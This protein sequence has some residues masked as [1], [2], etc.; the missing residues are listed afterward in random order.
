[1]RGSGA[2]TRQ[3]WF[4][5]V[6]AASSG[7]EGARASLACVRTA[8]RSV[9]S[10]VY[11]GEG[12]V[13]T[14]AHVVNECLGRE[15]FATSRPTS[16]A[17]HVF[18]P[19]APY[20]DTLTARLAVWIPARAEHDGPGASRPSQGASAV[21]QG[22]LAVLELDCEPP[23]PVRPA[24]WA[25]M[26]QEQRVRAWYSTGQPFTYADGQVEW[27]DAQL[28][29]VDA[30][31]RGAAIGPGYSGGP[32][33]CDG[34]Q[35]AVGVVLGVL[36][37]PEGPFRPGDVTRRTLALPWQAVRAEL[38]AVE[39]HPPGSTAPWSG[40][41]YEVALVDPGT[42]H[43]IAAVVAHLCADPERRA[44]HADRLT[45]ELGLTRAPGA[46]PTVD[47]IVDLLLT[48][49]RALAVLTEG[50]PGSEREAALKLLFLG[51]AAGVLG[52]LS[53]R[54]YRWLLDLLPPEAAARL[55][56][57]ARA[58]LP[59]TTLFDGAPGEV[60]QPPEA[61]CAPPPTDTTARLV[62]ALEG[63]WG[64][65][66][67]VPAGSPRVP[68]LL[69][70]MEY[71]AATYEEKRSRDLRDWSEQVAH[72]LGV[73]AE[74]LGER[75]DDAVA[76]ARRRQQDGT[77]AVPRLTVRLTRV[78]GETFRCE[79]W[80][81]S[82]MS[83]AAP[84]DAAGGVERLVV[85]DDMDR[86][87]AQIARLLHGVLARERT[88]TASPDA[89]G[90]LIEVLLEADDLDVAVDQ[91]EQETSP[92]EVPVVLG[93]EYAVVIRCP[94][95]RRRV[96]ERLPDWRARWAE[97]ERGGG[98][99]RLDRRHTTRHQVYG[100]LT[101]DPGLARVI[102]DCAEE[103][104]GALRA[105]CL[106]LGVPVVV[107]DRCA[108]PAPTGG[109]RLLA[110]VLNGPPKGLP[111]RVRRHRARALAEADDSGHTAVTPALVWDDASRLPPRALWSDPS[112]EDPA[113]LGR[114]P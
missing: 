45:G 54:E 9:G 12:R 72:R 49:P 103:H 100:L 90:V 43:G 46:V 76:W 70:A 1:M 94:E 50:L 32:L 18:F 6:S 113:A 87:P 84:G 77:P 97:L 27:C 64:D 88:P 86:T 30:G 61:S 11:L 38:E 2:R 59:H 4:R 52:L 105:M 58:A 106:A 42:R 21:W 35:A 91:W 28:G 26:A 15:P 112:Y 22:D 41:G 51:R 53:V 36:Q 62:E 23:A 80:Y 68:A 31:I 98:V 47:D 71:L 67:P 109:D 83:S 57:A 14:C 48:H 104:R 66:A 110:L 39:A 114:T 34:Q 24:E 102:V 96:P 56:E 81:E 33:W 69:R 85:S 65:S 99:L 40:A 93:A 44:E 82:G 37:P 3:L 79:A 25:D 74:A 7:A 17:V 92:Y 95:I 111:H 20:I 10:G 55:P 73:A 89:P 13:L 29:F 107:W 75:R 16:A 19:V 8:E 63:F 101:E 108:S 60:T 78:S 5:P